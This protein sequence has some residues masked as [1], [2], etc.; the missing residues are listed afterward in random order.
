VVSSVALSG[1]GQCPDTPHQVDKQFSDELQF[2]AHD[3]FRLSAALLAPYLPEKLEAFEAG[4]K[5][6]FFH[7]RF[8][9]NTASVGKLNLDASTAI[10]VAYAAPRTFGVAVGI[11]FMQTVVTIEYPGVNSP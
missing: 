6:Q 1:L 3:Q 2:V 5:T 11:K 4:L 7:R 8:T 9:F 10:A